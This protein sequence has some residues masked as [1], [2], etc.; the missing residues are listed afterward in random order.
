M[1]GNATALSICLGAGLLIAFPLAAHLGEKTPSLVLH[2]PLDEAT[3]VRLKDRSSFKN[4]GTI[5]GKPT[6]EA[7]KRGGALRFH[8]SATNA[9]VDVRPSASLNLKGPH[10]L[11]FWLRW[12]GKGAPWS[13]LMTKRP[14]D[15]TN[16]DHYSTWVRSDG[17]FEYR[18]DNGTVFANRKVPL[19]NKWT[20]LAVTHD[21]KANVTFFIDGATAGKKK[22]RRTTPN[23]GPFVVGSGRHLAGDFGAGAID[24]I[25]IFNRELTETE[26]KDLMDNGPGAPTRS[27]GLHQT[28]E[29]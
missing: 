22:L 17:R 7:G 28:G 27:R 24:E 9:F 10:P 11:S 8:G 21:G 12:D 4:H 29:R 23:T 16:P 1:K 14:V 25:A 6:R 20:F 13:P 2:L 19:T 26:I 3:G 18:T 15:V 5:N